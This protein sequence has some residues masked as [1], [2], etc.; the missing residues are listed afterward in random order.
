MNIFC[1]GCKCSLKPEKTGQYVLDVRAVG[2]EAI[3]HADVF[4]CPRCGVMITSGFGNQP[5]AQEWEQEPA[6][7][8]QLKRDLE[9]QEGMIRWEL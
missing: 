4:R 9:E 6:E 1:V 2:S 5:V 3:W 7:W 8:A